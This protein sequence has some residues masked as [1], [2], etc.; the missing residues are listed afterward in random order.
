MFNQLEGYLDGFLS[1]VPLDET[2]FNVY[3]PKLT[4]IILE[5]GPELISAFDVAVANTGLVPIWEWGDPTLQPDRDKLWT[6]E[7]KRKTKKRSLTFGDYFSFLNSHGPQRLGNAK[8]EITNFNA[9]FMPFEKKYPDWWETYN[10]LK[11]EKYNNLR[12]ATLEITLKLLGALFWLV[13]Y[14]IEVSSHDH[15][16]SNLFKAID[17]PKIETLKKLWKSEIQSRDGRLPEAA[18]QK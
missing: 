4:T 18:L 12:K 10:Q 17:G 8:V 3:S 7:E 11:H 14:N 6:E 16:R 15:C 13:D 5:A 1:Y 9:Y 2:H